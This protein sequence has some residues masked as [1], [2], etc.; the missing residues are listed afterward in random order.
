MELKKVGRLGTLEKIREWVIQS[1]SPGARVMM[2]GRY[3]L[4]AENDEHVAAVGLRRFAWHSTELRHLIV[5]PEKRG[6]GYGREIVRLALERVKTPL[7]IA[8]V[9]TTNVTS[10]LLLFTSGFRLVRTMETSSGEIAFLM[11]ENPAQVAES[12]KSESDKP[13]TDAA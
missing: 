7:T 8:T 2:E 6:H 4:L 5:P 11:R 12:P 3:F 13:T 9:H 10:L 1:R